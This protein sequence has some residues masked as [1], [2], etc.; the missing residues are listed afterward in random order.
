[1]IL[2]NSVVKKDCPLQKQSLFDPMFQGLALSLMAGEIVATFLTRLAVPVLYCLSE[3]VRPR[4][5]LVL[6]PLAE[7]VS[8]S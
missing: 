8:N 3:T 6:P 5:L 4:K 2:L 7:E 1:L